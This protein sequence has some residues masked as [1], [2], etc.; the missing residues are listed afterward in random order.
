MVPAGYRQTSAGGWVKESDGSGPYTVDTGDGAAGE[1]IQMPAGWWVTRS[2][3]G[4]YF[5][6]VTAGTR[7][8]IF[9]TAP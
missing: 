4:P 3:S 5:H 1:L 7:A 2:G 9:T 6:D 8:A